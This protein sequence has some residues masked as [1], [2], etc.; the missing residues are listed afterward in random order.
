LFS[1][2]ISLLMTPTTHLFRERD[3]TDLALLVGLEAIQKM[4]YE[5]FETELRRLVN[6]RI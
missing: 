6:R 1:S 4:S 3:V 2:D 5:Q